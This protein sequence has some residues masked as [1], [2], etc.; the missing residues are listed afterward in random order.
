MEQLPVTWA[1]FYEAAAKRLWLRHFD[2][3]STIPCRESPA[4][5][6]ASGIHDLSHAM[7]FSVSQSLDHRKAGFS[8]LN[9]PVGLSFQIQAWTNH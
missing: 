7:L 8:G 3:Y 5:P 1:Q 4:P 6:D 2:E 9:M